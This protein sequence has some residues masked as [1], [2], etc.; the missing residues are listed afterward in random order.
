MKDLLLTESGDLYL[1][2]ETGDIV[3]TDSV[4]QAAII[5]LKWFKDEWRINPDYGLPYYDEILIKNPNESLIRS[6]I[7]EELLSIDEVET[8]DDIEISID[9]KTRR[10]KITFSVTLTDGSDLTKEVSL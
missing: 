2:P 9:S 4:Q 10:A 6:R 5:R 7:S 1:S 3:I 8:V